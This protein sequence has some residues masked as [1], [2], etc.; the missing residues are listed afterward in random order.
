MFYIFPLYVPY[1]LHRSGRQVRAA[2][3]RI[4]VY[5]RFAVY[6]YVCVCILDNTHSIRLLVCAGATAQRLRGVPRRCRSS[7]SLDPSP[8][9]RPTA[10]F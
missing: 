7:P 10:A 4:F 6:T 3:P 8:S 2:S 5:A 9:W 1:I